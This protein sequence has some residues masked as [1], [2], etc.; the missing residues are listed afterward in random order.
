[1]KNLIYIMLFLIQISAS[2]QMSINTDNSQPDASAGLDVKFIDKGFLMPRMTFEQRNAIVAPAEG[3]MVFCT[4]CG[5]NGAM[6]IFSNGAWRTFSPCFTPIPTATANAVSP[7]QIIWHWNLPSVASGARWHTINNFDGATDMGTATSK[8]E[9]GISCETIYTRFVWSYNEC[10]NSSPVTLTQ[11]IS[12]IVPATPVQGTHTA[13][14]NSI[15]WNWNTVLNATG[16]KWNSSN[17]YATATDLGTATSKTETGLI[18][19]MVYPRFVWAYNGCGF[20]SPV[21]LSKSTESCMVCGVPITKV[22]LTSEGVAP[23]NKTTTYGTVM[24]IP[25]ETSKCWITSNLGADHQA[26]AVDDATEASAGWY[27][28]FNRKQG[29]KHDGATLTPAWTI[30]TIMENSDWQ[31]T[32]DPCSKE[33]GPTWRIPTMT[34]WINVRAGGNWT[35]WTEPYNSVL[36]LHAAGYLSRNN[37][38]LAYRNF[39]GLYSCS[40]QFSDLESNYLYLTMIEAFILYTEKSTALSV[41]CL[42]SITGIAAVTTTASTS[43]TQTTAICGGNVT[44]D[45]GHAVTERGICWSTTPY[46]TTANSKTINGSGTGSFTSNM[47]GLTTNTLYYVRSYATNSIATVYGDQVSFTT[48]VPFFLG[49]SYN[50]GK[51]FYVDGTGQHGLIASTSDQGYP[52][53]GDMVGWGCRP[54]SIPGTLTAIGT[55]AANTALIVA[56]GCNNPYYAAR[57]CNDLVL[58]GYNDWFLPS[59]DELNQLYLQRGLFSGFASGYY[60]SSSEMNADYAFIQLFTSAGTQNNSYKDNYWHVRA[61]RAF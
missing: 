17:N 26:T 7:G 44:S 49:Q 56:N 19:S 32:N 13:T 6:S 48:L 29:Y 45:G 31:N 37:G 21:S 41:R 22:H 42:S 61:I 58:N 59:K 20:S 33:L 1:M 36:K 40:S 57:V 14:V 9:T 10:G 35:S 38:N 11:T 23:V 5:T 18:C 52:S 51:I 39:Y 43:V 12:G 24:D 54:L 60:W 30:T 4:N 50:G 15:T 55:G 47:T 53:P 25:G 27:W 34:E 16:Y 2:A 8:T 3:L 28:Q 46:P